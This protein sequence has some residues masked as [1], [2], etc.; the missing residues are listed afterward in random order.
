MITIDQ[1]PS[2]TTGFNILTLKE[3]HAIAGGEGE[4]WDAYFDPKGMDDQ[5]RYFFENSIGPQSKT[6]AVMLRAFL[7]RVEARL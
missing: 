6:F 3:I 2:S 5:V 7:K 1:F 4:A